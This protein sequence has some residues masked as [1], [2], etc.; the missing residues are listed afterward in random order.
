MNTCS[1]AARGEIDERYNRILMAEKSRTPRVYFLKIF[2]I[3]NIC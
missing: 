3:V 1:F 2:E